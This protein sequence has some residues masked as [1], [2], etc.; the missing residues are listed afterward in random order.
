MYLAS[1]VVENPYISRLVTDEEMDMIRVAGLMHGIGHG[2]FSHVFE[3]LLIKHLKKTHEDV[4]W[5]IIENS[6]LCDKISNMGYKPQEMGKLAVGSLHKSGKAFLDQI[7][8]SAID[9]DKQNFIVRDPFHTGAE[10]GVI[11]VFR[12]IHAL[13]VLG[14]DL[15]VAFGALSALEAIMIARIE[16]FKSIYF[17]CVGRAAQNH[18][19][20]GEGERRARSDCI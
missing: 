14:E 9:V 10:D 8:S 20:Y 13:D 18:A 15:A 17:H 4:T 12:L 3:Q 19:G 16:S 1:K 11:D 6:D 7:I 5:W 2:P